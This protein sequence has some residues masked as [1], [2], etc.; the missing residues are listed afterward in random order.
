MFRI[1]YAACKSDVYDAVYVWG[2][3]VLCIQALLH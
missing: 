3:G 2:V 1:E